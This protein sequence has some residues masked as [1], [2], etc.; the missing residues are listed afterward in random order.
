MCFYICVYSIQTN[1]LALMQYIQ[2]DTYFFGLC[3]EHLPVL[4]KVHG[5]HVTLCRTP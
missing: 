3:G 4:L 2:F 1:M 5:K